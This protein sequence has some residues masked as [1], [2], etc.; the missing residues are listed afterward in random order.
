MNLRELTI[1]KAKEL[2]GTTFDVPLEDGKTTTLRLDEV[3][4]YALQSRR[5]SRGPEPKREPFALY[6]LG[7]P[8]FV[9]PQGMYTLRSAAT[10]LDGVFLVPIGQDEKATEYEAVFT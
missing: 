5:R 2:E 9:L 1:E 10:T 6:L 3:A 4:S 7:D 8:S